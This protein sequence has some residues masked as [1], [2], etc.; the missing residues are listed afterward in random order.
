MEQR[1][2]ELPVTEANFSL[3]WNA[4]HDREQRLLRV[5]EYYGEDS[6]EAALAANDLVG[7]RLYMKG[8]RARVEPVFFPNVFVLDE[9]P[10]K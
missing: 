2:I 9:T 7:L 4:L 1:R 6:D 8:L 3:I 5:I 10:V